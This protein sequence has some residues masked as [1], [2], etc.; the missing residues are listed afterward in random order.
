MNGDPPDQEERD[1][2]TGG[3]D[4][5]VRA[6][7]PLPAG[8]V[9]SYGPDTG[10]VEKPHRPVVLTAKR[11]AQL[12]FDA[13]GAH[14]GPGAAEPLPTQTVEDQAAQARADVANRAVELELLLANP[15]LAEPQRAMIVAE[16]ARLREAL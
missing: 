10:A 9:R 7:V 5:T 2:G 12:P 6:A 11:Q 14:V 16:I 8:G 15:D 3:T 1:E 4:R 13:R